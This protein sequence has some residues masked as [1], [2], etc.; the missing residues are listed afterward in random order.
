MDK[1]LFA[2][3]GD[4]RGTKSQDTLTVS[5]QF[6][7]E[8]DHLAQTRGR[9]FLL[10]R[11]KGAVEDNTRAFAQSI[12]TLFKEK[13]YTIGGSNLKALAETID[14]I[15]ANFNQKGVSADI[16]AAN[17]WGS[18]LYLAKLGKGGFLLV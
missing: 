2:Q 13:F 1:T 8:D 4:I 15:K 11:V 7:P 18:V 9:L 17:L 5:F 6:T 3:T 10:I 16:L 14:F 12:Y